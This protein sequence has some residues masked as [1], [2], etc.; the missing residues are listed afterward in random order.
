MRICGV[1]TYYGHIRGGRHAPWSS[2]LAFVGGWWVELLVEREKK[3]RFASQRERFSSS[4][5]RFGFHAI[6]IPMSYY[7]QVRQNFGNRSW[8]RSFG[9]SVT[10]RALP[11]VRGFW[12]MMTSTKVG[13]FEGRCSGAPD[14]SDKK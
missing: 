4:K 11:S 10:V 3:D 7:V 6:L 9:H 2:T 1:S 12:E 13:R 14:T 8:I 5:G